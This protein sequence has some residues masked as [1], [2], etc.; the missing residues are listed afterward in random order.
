MVE[1]RVPHRPKTDG[2]AV[3]L[4]PLNPRDQCPASAGTLAPSLGWAVDFL[5]LIASVMPS[6]LDSWVTLGDTE[7]PTTQLSGGSKSDLI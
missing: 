5:H 6:P 7:F 1:T 3:F 2:R 4:R